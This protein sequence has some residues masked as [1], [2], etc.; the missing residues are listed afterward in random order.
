MKRERWGCP[1][2]QSPT[3]IYIY[4]YIYIYMWICKNISGKV[5]KTDHKNGWSL[6]TKY[7]LNPLSEFFFIHFFHLW[8][9]YFLSDFSNLFFHTYKPHL[10]TIYN[11][12][13]IILG[14]TLAI[15]A[16]GFH[17]MINF[18]A[19]HCF[20]GDNISTNR[21]T[22]TIPHGYLSCFSFKV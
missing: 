4:I 17:L 8:F 12:I 20:G 9:F 14:K 7:Q 6:R 18:R 19:T 22:L 16:K 10:G 15:S 3:Y 21:K 2:L 1:R 11:F 5:D 13:Q